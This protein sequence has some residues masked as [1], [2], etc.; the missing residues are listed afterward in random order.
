ML[1]SPKLYNVL[2]TMYSVYSIQSNNI[3][4][5]IYSY[6]MSLLLIRIRNIGILDHDLRWYIFVLILLYYLILISISK[7]NKEYYYMILFLIK[8]Y[9]LT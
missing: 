7:E 3:H 1:D 6:T 2:C 9:I 4:N 8:L 5:S